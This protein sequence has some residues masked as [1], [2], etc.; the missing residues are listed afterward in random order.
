MTP[1]L[2]L[3]ER[4]PIQILQDR[5]LY[6]NDLVRT[7]TYL[8]LNDNELRLLVTVVEQ[9]KLRQCDGGYPSCLHCQDGGASCEYRAFQG[10]LQEAVLDNR[11]GLEQRLKV[12]EETVQRLRKPSP[13]RAEELDES[14]SPQI[15]IKELPENCSKLHASFSEDDPGSFKNTEEDFYGPSSNI[16]YLRQILRGINSM[17]LASFRG[18]DNKFLAFIKPECSPPAAIFHVE[19]VPEVR[20]ASKD[21]LYVL[22]PLHATLYLVSLFFRD[23][24]SMNPFLDEATFVRTHVDSI[25]EETRQPEPSKLALLDMVLAIATASSMDSIKPAI[26]RL[27]IS[28]L[29]FERSK[30]LLCKNAF[31]C[32]N[33]EQVQCYLLMGQ[34]LQSTDR[35]SDC[36]STHCMA[37]QKAL[38]QG[39]HNEDYLAKDSNADQEAKRRTWKLC[40]FMD[41]AFSMHFRRPCLLGPFKKQTDLSTSQ[42]LTSST[43]TPEPSDNGLDEQSSTFFHQSFRLY[44]LLG[45]I[46]STEYFQSSRALDLSRFMDIIASTANLS[47]DLD[48]WSDSLPGKWQEA[49]LQSSTVLEGEVPAR[50]NLAIVLSLRYHNVRLMLHRPVIVL[51]L[52][53]ARKS[54]SSGDITPATNRRLVL[55][56]RPSLDA[57]MESAQAIVATVNAL[58][59]GE[60]GKPGPGMWWTLVQIVYNAV[61][62][63]FAVVCL[64]TDDPAFGRP[65]AVSEARAYIDLARQAFSKLMPDQPAVERASTFLKHISRLCDHI[66]QQNIGATLINSIPDIEPSHVQTSYT[67]LESV[68]FDFSM[69]EE[70][71][72]PLLPGP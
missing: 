19:P 24:G 5:M 69:F 58:E 21:E 35:C 15:I 20:N 46:I 4:V 22:P 41:S 11:Q 53:A 64:Q 57:S 37:V 60:E 39:L 2:A 1:K 29:F 30:G 38:G 51:A 6:T 54:V 42:S 36:W 17:T 65:Q 33:L 72:N 55:Y 56:S 50:S 28:R 32:G 16:F 14:D 34:Y 8:C 25:Y 18:A 63:C 7:E 43:L 47:R 67:G 71:Y 48:N 27:S 61:L 45:Q 3:V 13:P 10:E 59:G 31:D 66:V 12:L 68:P 23:Y 44:A 62:T 49:V 40:L 9:G 70:L 52:T 26:R